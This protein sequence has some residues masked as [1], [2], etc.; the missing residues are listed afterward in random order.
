[1]EMVLRSEVPQVAVESGAGA[2]F[3][4]WFVGVVAFSV[5]VVAVVVAAPWAVE[6]VRENRIGPSVLGVLAVVG[7][8]WGGVAALREFAASRPVLN[9]A[10]FDAI[11]GGITSLFYVFAV[12]LA[13]GCGWLTMRSRRY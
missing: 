8:V 3:M 12:G 11:S 6:S 2:G 7:L 13:L 9:I 4:W 10:I 1:M 5:A